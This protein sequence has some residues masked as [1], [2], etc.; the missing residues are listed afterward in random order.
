MAAPAGFFRYTSVL[1]FSAAE[2]VSA[3]L[4]ST[5]LDRGV[6]AHTRAYAAVAPDAGQG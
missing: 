6:A 2:Y 4:R 5:P 1:H 3:R